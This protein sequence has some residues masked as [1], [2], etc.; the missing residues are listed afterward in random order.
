M[1]E[2]AAIESAATSALLSI[3][4]LPFPVA[5]VVR[6][7]FV[8]QCNSPW[9]S[10]AGTADAF[11][12]VT[13][14]GVS[15]ADA[16][17]L[18]SMIRAAIAE[19]PGDAG[20]KSGATELDIPNLE[21]V[22]W[23]RCYA[24]PLADDQ[25]V[26]SIVPIRSQ[27][28]LDRADDVRAVLEDAYAYM[29]EGV[30]ILDRDLKV[31]LSTGFASNLLGRPGYANE[32]LFAFDQIHPADLPTAV[33]TVEQLLTRAGE[34]A[35]IE[36]RLATAAGGWRWFEAIT[37]NLIEHP[38]VGGILVLLRDIGARKD[39][40]EFASRIVRLFDESPDLVLV[41]DRA[42]RPIY[43]NAALTNLLMT[44]SEHPTE[45]RHAERNLIREVRRRLPR[46]VIVG[47][48]PTWQGEA[49]IDLDG[50]RTLS[51]VIV[52]SQQDGTTAFIAG[53]GR[54]ITD[55]K[56][57]EAQLE[58]QASHDSL[59][60]LP[61]RVT[62]L[63][64]LAGALAVQASADT[65]LG[66]L[67][68]DLDNLKDVND[69]VGHHVG[70]ALLIDV[71]RR[72]RSA[73][74]PF[75][76]VARLGGDEFAVL[77]RHLPD[78][79]T[80]HDVAERVRREL[81]GRSI[82][83]RTDVFLSASIGIV[84]AG[85]HRPVEVSPEVDAMAVLRD[86]DTAMYRAKQLGRARVET[87]TEDLRARA[88]L[89]RQLTADL[90][91]AISNDELHIDFQPIYSLTEGRFTS[92]ETLLRWRHPR[93]GELAPSSFI[94]LAEE[95][96]LIEPIGRWV[97]ESAVRDIASMPASIPPVSLHVNV[98][99][100]QLSSADDFAE[101]ISAALAQWG[102]EPSRLTLEIT[103][104]TLLDA[105]AEAGARLAEVRALGVCTAIDDFGTGYSSLAYLRRFAMEELKLD[106]TFVRDLH[107]EPD[108]RAVVKA[109]ID[110]AHSLRM[111]V[112]AEE[113]SEQEQ[114]DVLRDLG[115]DRVQGFLLAGSTDLAGLVER[116]ATPVPPS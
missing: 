4:D 11:D 9:L 46:Q 85:P 83:D 114:L 44:H 32:G 1:T 17:R 95:S 93:L 62:F 14:T 53:I 34:Q 100:R 49:H 68:L 23:S 90:E 94:D 60:D 103:E 27:P 7:G 48:Q 55:R 108:S 5:I 28:V 87:F 37:T 92:V 99:P 75:D 86:A 101:V 20:A 80:A 111:V 112:T 115:C 31:L 88:H 42:T 35:T 104:S 107:T 91:Q 76:V 3:H 8:L 41:L 33:K 25:A 50:G 16:L 102:F 66:V 82:I 10:M 79:E 74:R 47:T 26:I 58:H 40:E 39:A 45:R 59:T 96:G 43:R 2:R 71:A 89:R 78:T 105:A 97:L 56:R 12:V 113:V 24:A 13:A 19:T 63:R 18:N 106:G 29:S 61:N 22:R 6:S 69:S 57:L 73:I 65:H 70:D 30:V 116:L 72:L 110:L 54:D 15:V 77:C 38:A 51:L 98:S 81:T 21:L 64:E 52:V 84:T 36:V 67:F 109:V